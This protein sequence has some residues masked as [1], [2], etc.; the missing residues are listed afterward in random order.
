V[1]SKKLWT[2]IVDYIKY[3]ISIVRFILGDLIAN[4]I[5]EMYQKSLL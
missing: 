2:Y 3:Y 5:N 1:F 4:E